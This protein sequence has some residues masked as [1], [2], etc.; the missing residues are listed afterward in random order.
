MSREW[1][2]VESGPHTYQELLHPVIVKN[3]GQWKYHTRPR[4]G[5]LKHV[6]KSGDVIYTVRAGTHRQVTV[7]IVRRLCDLA[8]RY[9]DG[10]LRWTVRNNVEF[11]TPNEANVAPLIKELEALGHPVGGTGNSISAIAHTQGWLHCDIPATDA[12]GVVKSMMDALF[13]D[14]VKEEMPNRVRLSTSCCEINC[15]GQADIAVVVQHTR[16]PRINHEILKN[17][18]EMP[19][20]VARCPVAAIRPTTVNGQP[21]LMV[22]EEKCIF[23][24]AC[25]GACPAMEINHP[26]YSK[27][28]VWVGGKNSNARTRPANM[29][30]VCHG[31]PNNPQRWPEVTEVVKRIL[32]AYKKG[33]REWERLGEWADRIGWK[34]FFEETG[35][36]FDKYMIDN[37]RHARVSFNQSA[38]VRF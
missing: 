8:D 10:H 26:D 34:R 12:S 25:F 22:V 7:D 31:L 3:Y 23:C 14:F 16:P 18:C 33:G 2:T 28:A 24:G 11:V 38:H 27:L 17:I 37:Y 6:A 32:G 36:P 30:L 21:S 13:D 29:K 20:T 35:L 19:S 15:G 1:K 9:S 4:P 5:V